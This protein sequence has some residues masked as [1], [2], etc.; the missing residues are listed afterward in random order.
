MCQIRSHRGENFEG[1]A[2]RM[3]A[4]SAKRPAVTVEQ[5]REAARDWVLAEVARAPGFHGAFHHGSL[6][7]LPDDAAVPAGSD[8]DVGVVWLDA[9]ASGPDGPLRRGRFAREGVV[10]DVSHLPRSQLAS[11]DDVLGDHHL[12]GSFRAPSVIADPSGELT[13]LQAAV[14]AHFAEP[15]WVRARCA[16]A[17]AKGLRHLAALR[18]SQP[19]HDQVMVWLFG[20]S[21]LATHVLLTAGLQNPTVRRRYAALREL[22]AAHHRLDFYETLLDA[23]GCEKMS[24][25]RVRHHLAGLTAAFDAA[26]DAIASPFMWEADLT[27]LARP[28]AVDGSRALIDRGLHREAVFWIAATYARCMAVFAA[29]APLATQERFGA[30][31]GGL[32]ADLGVETFDDRRRRAEQ[33][34]GLL[35]RVREVAEA[36]MAANLRLAGPGPGARGPGA[37]GPGTGGPGTGIGR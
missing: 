37:G 9:H 20:G 21:I 8:V 6:G 33:V 23:L 1:P 34:R 30:G 24:P 10:L 7:W 3:P 31:F 5:A 16:C 4:T 2:A 19:L 36:L 26:K 25:E 28:I 32:L 11:P 13:R 15:A 22:L 12:A 14:A 18:D 27:D 29:D 17:E 35:P